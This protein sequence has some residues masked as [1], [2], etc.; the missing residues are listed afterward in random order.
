MIWAVQVTKN[1]ETYVDAPTF[2]CLTEW[3][4]NQ[5]EV[6]ADRKSPVP[7]LFRSRALAQDHIRELKECDTVHAI[8]IPAKLAFN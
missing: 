7:Y 2:E 4:P 8:A 1:G 6:V 5:F 3:A